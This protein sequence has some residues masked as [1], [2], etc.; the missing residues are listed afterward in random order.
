MDCDS[1]MA[2]LNQGEMQFGPISFPQWLFYLRIPAW[3]LAS[4]WEV[5]KLTCFPLILI[6]H[7]LK[8][9]ALTWE[10]KQ[11]TLCLVGLMFSRLPFQPS[12]N[13]S[14][15]HQSLTFAMKT[16]SLGHSSLQGC[17]SSDR[18]LHGTP[19]TGW[20]TRAGGSL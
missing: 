17:W 11:N 10:S 4:V 16:S 9:I 7:S 1:L 8:K 3:I 13:N 20:M 6:F 19:A 12:K 14:S 15:C 18:K 5:L 2:Y